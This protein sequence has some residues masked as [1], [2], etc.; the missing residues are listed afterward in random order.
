MLTGMSRAVARCLRWGFLA[1][2]PTETRW[3]EGT[4]HGHGVLPTARRAVILILNQ[5]LNQIVSL[6]RIS[7]NRT[8]GASTPNLSLRDFLDIEDLPAY[9]SALPAIFSLSPSSVSQ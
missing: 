7:C 8:K 5:I 2:Y 4:P 1:R 9:G 3:R 6:T